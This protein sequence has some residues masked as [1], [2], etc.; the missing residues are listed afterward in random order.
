MVDH[1][2][3]R[4][5]ALG[6]ACQRQQLQ[7]SPSIVRPSAPPAP[8]ALLGDIAWR[9]VDLARATALARED[10]IPEQDGQV[11]RGDRIVDEPARDLDRGEVS[12]ETTKAVHLFRRA[13]P[14]LQAG[15][16]AVASRTRVSVLGVAHE[17]VLRLVRIERP[18]E[19]HE[20]VPQGVGAPGLVENC[21][22]AIVDGHGVGLP[23]EKK[24][25]DRRDR[26]KRPRPSCSIRSARQLFERVVPDH[27]P[28]EC[29]D[30]P[31]LQGDAGQLADV[32]RAVG[33]ED[34]EVGRRSVAVRVAKVG[35]PLEA[36]HRLD[37]PVDLGERHLHRADDVDATVMVAEFPAQVVAVR[38]DFPS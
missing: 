35:I 2:A 19:R 5:D 9:D 15:L 33:Q 31:V 30:A 36:I 32:P 26:S 1:P 25:V 11:D 17:C 3:V 14:A 8:A 38:H 16:S 37:H 4:L 28:D 29:L 27:L 12:S 13:H 7:C 34:R 23:D 20:R 22:A 21:A 6:E 24:V 10:L 18:A